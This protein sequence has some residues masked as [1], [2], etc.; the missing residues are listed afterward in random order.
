M[1][2]D[3]RAEIAKIIGRIQEEL[4]PL[5]DDIKSSI[6]SVRDEEQESKDNMAQSFQDGD[7]GQKCD[8]AINNFESAISDIEGFDLESLVGYLEEA[9]A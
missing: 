8:E 2:K 4:S 5:L 7:A 9:S 3:R 1:N 6:E